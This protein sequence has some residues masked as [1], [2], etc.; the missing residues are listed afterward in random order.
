[1]SSGF[2][3]LRD[4]ALALLAVRDTVSDAELL[5]HVYGGKLPPALSQRLLEPL[6][7]EARIERLADGR[8]RAVGGHQPAAER[9][10]L[11]DAPLTVAALAATGPRPRRSRILAISALHLAPLAEGAVVER[12]SAT[13][14]PGIRVPGYVVQRAGVAPD[15]LDSLPA[16]VE[17]IDDLIS[18]LGERP[19]VAQ[20]VALAW[21][22]LAS[23]AQ[24]LGRHLPERQLVDVNQLAHRVLELDAKPTLAL[25]A[26]RLGIPIGRIEQPDEEARVLSLVV[27]RLLAQ[28]AALGVTSLEA[29]ATRPGSLRRAETARNL[30]DLPGV[31][32]LRDAQQAALYVGKARRLSGRMAA[33]VH[34][35]LGATRRLEGLA[36]AVNAVEV[37]VCETDL[38]A[39]I[40]EDREIR[41]LRPRFNTQRQ[42]RAPRVWIRRPP[43]PAARAGK[44]QLAPPRLELVE[45]PALR[46][47]EYLGPFRNPTAAQH[48]RDLAREVFDLDAIRRAG[49]RA[50]HAEQL[51][52]AWSFLNGDADLALAVARSALAAA[53]SAGDHAAVR[54]WERHLAAIRAY[55]ARQELLPADPRSAHYAVVRPGPN[56]THVEVFVLDRGILV[57]R[58]G[59]EACTA[60]PDLARWCADLLASSAPRT[61]SADREVVLRWLGAQRSSA[62]LVHL[63][64]DPRAAAASIEGAITDLLDA[65]APAAGEA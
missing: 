6:L 16:L 18:F 3:A 28:A 55:D 56:G 41:R 33:Y 53:V 15:V 31:Y 22:F 32:V 17:V 52:L 39:L 12:F 50:R 54:R 65:L 34:R 42:L 40:L 23:E 38:E 29:P 48:A 43:Q 14:N 45:D 21:E 46:D 11:P 58:A 61:Q 4:R 24:R 35:P 25:V 62:R 5:E 9:L 26:G 64:D 27:P 30:P 47:G 49:D 57:A 37:D 7:A 10:P 2:L 1:M 59:L 8:W 63:A 51:Q 19:L 60:E 13:L 36:D 44:R 20:E